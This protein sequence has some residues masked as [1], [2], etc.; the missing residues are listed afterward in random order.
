[1]ELIAHRA[2]NLPG[3]VT[4]AL[5][6]ADA[7]ELDLHLFRGRLEVR[8]AKVLFWPFARLW[9]KWELLPR[10][11]PRPALAV[12]VGVVPDDARL[13]LDL[14]GFTTRLPRAVHDVVGDR[15]G[16]TYSSRHWWTL[17]WVRRHTSART[18]RSVGNRWQRGL[19]VRLGPV[20]APHGVVIHERLLDPAWARQLRRVAPT[21][22]AWGVGDRE[23]AEELLAVGVDGLILDDVDLIRVLRSSVDEK[24]G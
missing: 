5:A 20:V 18:M 3:L 9:E 24:S 11:T 15:P 8:H 2:G 22:I 23:R 17:R 12:I 4:P 10:T 19:V 13:W 6:V 7:I 14:K 21:L 1:M 16:T